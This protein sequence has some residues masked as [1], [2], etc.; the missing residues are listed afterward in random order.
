MLVFAI[1]DT[2]IGIPPDKKEYIFERFAQ[3]Y[4]SKNKL[5]G[6]TGLGLSIVKGLVSILGGNIWLESELEK[7]STFYFSI[8]YHAAAAINKE[9]ISDNQNENFNFEAIKLL[10]VEDDIYNM[11]YLCEILELYGFTILQADLGKQAVKI[12]LEQDPDIILMDIL[13]PDLDG[14]EATKQIKTHKPKIKIIAQTAFAAHEDKL[15]TIQY[16][17]DD[18][19]SKPIK[20]NLLIE[21][22]KKHINTK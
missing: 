13:L 4:Q 11:E 1:S 21:L 7:G 6:G 5:Y 17:F 20:E 16:G 18:Y 3:V 14:Y 22:I 12:A 9:P 19:I 2:G 8:P 10:I 15:K